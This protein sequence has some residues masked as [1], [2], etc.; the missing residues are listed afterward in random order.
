MVDIHSH[1]LPQLDDGSSSLEETLQ[2]MGMLK[3]QGVETIVATPHFYAH[4]DNLDAFLACR[5]EAYNQIPQG[6]DLPPV[7]LGAE[8]AYFNGMSQV[9]EITKLQLGDTGL[10]LVEM[11]FSPWSERI[12]QDVCALTAQTGLVPVLA[13][14]NRY[15]S[16]LGRYGKRLLEQGVLFQCNADAFTE[17]WSRRWALKQ[18][19]QGKIHFLGSDCHNLTNR[20]PLLDF[21]KQTILNKLGQNALDTITTMENYFQ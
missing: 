16:Q 19:S 12:V 17:F 8:V 1:I 11:P 18:I 2:L 15:R 3:E 14:V 13:H 5:Q 4:M 20:P 10:L 7:I 21:A 9:Q 6:E